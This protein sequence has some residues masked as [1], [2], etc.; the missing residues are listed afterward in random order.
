MLTILIADDHAVVREGL[1]QILAELEDSVS[2][3]EASHGQEVLEKILKDRF[4]IILLD[5]SMP[6]MNGLDILK[7]IKNETPDTAVLILSM[8]PEEQYAVR[9]LK[10]GASGYLTKESAPEE[11]IQAIQR[12]ATGRKY[13]TP[14][15]AEKL[16]YDFDKDFEKPL[17]EI[18]SDREFQV[19][20]LLAVG[21][22]VKEIGKELF[23]SIKTVSTYRTRILEKMEFKNNAELIHY[24]IRNKLI[25]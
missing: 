6:D 8:Y 4:D 5:I 3:A 12:I 11:L 7:Q 13:I 19:M 10:A 20:R 15:L 22:T 25:D 23:L 1:K 14:S 17:H 18:L 9:A 24:S 2:L 16:A 21:K